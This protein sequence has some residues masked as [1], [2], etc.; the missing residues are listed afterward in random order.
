M[1]IVYAPN[2]EF[3]RFWVCV[4]VFFSSSTLSV[5]YS[6]WCKS[7][8]T[9]TIKWINKQKKKPHTIELHNNETTSAMKILYFYGGDAKSNFLA[10]LCIRANKRWTINYLKW[11]WNW[12]MCESRNEIVSY[13]L[14]CRPLAIFR[15]K[16]M[17]LTLW[18]S[19]LRYGTYVPYRIPFGLVYSYCVFFYLSLLFCHRFCCCCRLCVCFFFC[20]RFILPLREILSFGICIS[21]SLDPTHSHKRVNIEHIINFHVNAI[22]RHK[23]KRWK[24]K[25]ENRTKKRFFARWFAVD[26]R[27]RNTAPYS[28]I[29][30]HRTN[31]SQRTILYAFTFRYW[32]KQDC[33]RH[34]V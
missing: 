13:S 3:N 32:P 9:Y 23:R 24:Q 31:D 22:Y 6:V 10:I 25:K 28:T 12:V 1:H 20:I 15:G 27:K 18:N 26:E 7:A 17:I 29:R 21:A 2:T 33:F 16:F 30:L 4:C 19:S 11:D 34:C 14:L 5:V 8:H